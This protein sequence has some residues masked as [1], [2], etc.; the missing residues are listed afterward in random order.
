MPKG[1]IIARLTVNDPEAYKAYAA[2][3]S[4][5]MKIYGATILARGG[6]SEA[7]EGDARPRNVIL[8]FPS[9]EAARTYYDSPEYQAAINL[10][11]PVSEGELVLVE[12]Y[13]A[14]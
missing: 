2:A 10:R 12:G 11:R 7:L 8:E 4:A 5:A 14:P 13:D 9:Y 6:R 1:Y 3:A